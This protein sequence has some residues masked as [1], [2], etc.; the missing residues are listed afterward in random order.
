MVM[1]FSAL[2]DFMRNRAIE[3][4][5]RINQASVPY[6]HL[7]E[8]LKAASLISTFEGLLNS[9]RGWP[10]AD[11]LSEFEEAAKL[12]AAGPL[13]SQYQFSPFAFGREKSNLNPDDISI[14]AG[15]FGVKGFWQEATKIKAMTGAGTPQDLQ[16]GFKQMARTRHKAAH[17][18]SHIVG[19]VELSTS[20]SVS[21]DVAAGFDILVSTATDRLGQANLA[22]GGTMQEVTSADVKITFLRP[23]VRGWAGFS[24]SSAKRAT[25]VEPAYASAHS[26]A[27]AYAKQ[28]NMSLVKQDGASRVT[29]WETCLG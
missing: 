2:E 3:C 6:S 25:F 8:K 29:G 15:R 19:H 23:H 9:S 1:L 26:R 4:T 13:G 5:Q 20:L 17:V 7:P 18:P 14:M 24:S 27:L 10:A 22:S 28:R 21:I 12:A 16:A 11:R